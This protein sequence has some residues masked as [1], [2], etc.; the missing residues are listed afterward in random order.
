LD[1]SNPFQSAK[2]PNITVDKPPITFTS[3]KEN[4]NI[5]WA[6]KKV[7]FSSKEGR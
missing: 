3:G 7:Q 4:S 5:P 2:S 1:Q 6:T